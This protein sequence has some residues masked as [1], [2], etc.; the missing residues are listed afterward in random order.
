MPS[1]IPRS[2]FSSPFIKTLLVLITIVIVTMIAL[3]FINFYPLVLIFYAEMMGL[4]IF[5]PIVTKKEFRDRSN[6]EDKYA[7]DRRG[8][9]VSGRLRY[10]W[11]S[12]KGIS[13]SV[14]TVK[15]NMTE[16]ITSGRFISIEMVSQ[17]PSRHGELIP[18][19]STV[20]YGV[21]EISFRIS[22]SPHVA[23]KCTR[24]QRKMRS[25]LGKMR[26]VSRNNNPDIDFRLLHTDS[27]ANISWETL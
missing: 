2:S 7:F 8:I 4:V 13:F 25:L 14:R 26:D 24:S 15:H 5:L 27:D 20:K 16:S 10:P 21:M 12:I 23:I 1:R 3:N 6:S 17:I 19:I 9:L 22:S 11:D 18:I